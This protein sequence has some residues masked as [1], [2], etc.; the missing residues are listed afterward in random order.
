MK[1]FGK[2]NE[3]AARRVRTPEQQKQRSR[4]LRR[5]S[6]SG[7]SLA[8]VL[9]A[10]ILLNLVCTSL[11]DQYHLTLDL[12][13]NQ[14]YEVTQD[15]VDMLEGLDKDVTITILA[16][17]DDFQK[18]SYYSYVYK[19]MDKYL[20]YAR[21]HVTVTYIDP[22]T[23]PNAASKFSELSAN[24]QTGSVI[25]QCGDKSRVLAESDFY[26]T[27]QD[28]T[29]GYTYVTGFAAEQAFTSAILA[30]T[31]DDTPA[32]Y[33]VQGHNESVSSS[34]SA[35][36]ENSG[37]TIS[38]LT[39]AE[40]EIPEDAAIVV[41]SLPQVDFTEE[42]LNQLDAYVKKGGDLMVFDGTSVPT[43]LDNL[44]SYLKEWGIQVENDMVIDANYN[45][46]QTPTYLFAQLAES[47]DN[48]ALSSKADQVIVAP[49]AKSLTVGLSDRASE[50]RSVETLLESHDGSYSKEL[51]EDT[52]RD[53]YDKED[54][55]KE[56]PFALAALARYTGNDKGG[57]IFV[58]SAAMMMADD[59]M[60]VSS[61]LNQRFLSNVVSLQ[62][63]EVNM[64]TIASKSMASEPLT[65]GTGA[66]FT[67]F[68]ILCLIPLAL[69]FCG[70]QVFLRRRHL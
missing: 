46:S 57:T 15:S 29:Y 41:I 45:L 20:G 8:L 12:T 23:N 70:L 4:R 64:V 51:T 53:S 11:T 36:L 54:G 16:S 58:C 17:E 49:N 32:V 35:M 44:K 33:L 9:V 28:S 37:Y 14:M 67:V 40:D 27:E 68:V 61:L 60:E 21:G 30:V 55:D 59:L 63:P 22:K 38:T 62:Q 24:V 52:N 26:E 2:K 69:F 50:D 7:A 5:V 13:A 47:D 3:D 10:V 31:S 18:D 43:N 39:L 65:I 6:I 56:G 25:F 19:F 42:E 66:Q 1:F 34:F 48:A